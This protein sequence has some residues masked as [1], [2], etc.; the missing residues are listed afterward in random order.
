ML[1]V[2]PKLKLVFTFRFFS[3]ACREYH[4]I[5]CLPFARSRDSDIKNMSRHS[6]RPPELGATACQT[7]GFSQKSIKIMLFC[8]VIQWFWTKSCLTSQNKYRIF[9]DFFSRGS[10]H[11]LETISRHSNR[12][13]N[14][15][16]VTFDF[17]RFSFSKSRFLMVLCWSHTL[18][19]ICISLG[20]SWK[21]EN[22]V[23]DFQKITRILILKLKNKKK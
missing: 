7:R 3:I 17:F 23:I 19:P 12:M 5:R 9:V 22:R 10:F 21:H 15:Y 11:R 4:R 1:R 2:W 18:I 16:Y 6:E 14:S 8:T 20:G 13:I